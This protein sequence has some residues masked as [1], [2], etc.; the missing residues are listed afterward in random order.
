MFATKYN[1]C[2]FLLV[3][4]FL[5]LFIKRAYS[6]PIPLSEIKAKSLFVAVKYVTYLDFNGNPVAPYLIARKNMDYLNVNFSQCNIGFKLEQFVATKPTNQQLVFS[7]SQNEE[8]NTIRRSFQS[9]RELV[10]ITT[11]KWNR[12]GS[13]GESTAN[14]WTNLPGEGL[15]GIVM[16]SVVSGYSQ[17]IAHEIGHYFNLHHVNDST[18]PMNPIIYENSVK[19][20]PSQ[21]NEMRFIIQNYW[22]KMIRTSI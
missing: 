15:Y 2:L 8:L 16:E 13:L 5:S 17:I 21:C 7:P 3:I 9:E 10:L 1:K 6:I 20:Y 4:F 19:F 14:A 22:K 18:N 12:R 11:G